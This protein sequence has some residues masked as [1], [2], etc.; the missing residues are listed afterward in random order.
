MF[1]SS[2]ISKLLR[3]EMGS[4]LPGWTVVVRQVGSL[5][6]CLELRR[7]TLDPRGTLPVYH[8]YNPRCDELMVCIT[9]VIAAADRLEAELEDL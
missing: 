1:S 4:R 3:R 9:S 8:S 2:E 7:Q 6:W 5:D